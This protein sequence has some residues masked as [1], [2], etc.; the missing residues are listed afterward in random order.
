MRREKKV[1]KIILNFILEKL[2]NRAIKVDNE[3][4]LV[5]VDWAL[6]TMVHYV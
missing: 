5:V 1:G 2:S 6:V 3:D 4:K